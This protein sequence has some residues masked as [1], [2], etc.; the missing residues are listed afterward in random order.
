M[1]LILLWTPHEGGINMDSSDK[2]SKHNPIWRP[3]YVFK[4]I[5]YV[6]WEVTYQ[7]SNM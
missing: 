3:H 7:Q 1:Q 4:D 5:V 6:W 2:H